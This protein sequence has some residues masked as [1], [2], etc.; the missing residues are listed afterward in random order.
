[1]R[2]RITITIAIAA[3]L[4]CGMASAAVAQQSPSSAA[5]VGQS[6]PPSTSLLDTS[7]QSRGKATARRERLPVIT[8]TSFTNR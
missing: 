7:P 8:P 6:Q 3:L 2:A 5:P 1:M 4:G